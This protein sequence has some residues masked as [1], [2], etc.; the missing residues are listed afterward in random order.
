MVNTRLTTQDP[1]LLRQLSHVPRGLTEIGI[2]YPEARSYGAILK[3]IFQRRYVLPKG[4]A[5]TFRGYCAR[6]K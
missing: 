4:H 6:S 3:L 2:L 1:R 5:V